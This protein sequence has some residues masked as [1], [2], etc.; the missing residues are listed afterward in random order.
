MRGG[1]GRGG[2]GMHYRGQQISAEQ[3]CT[4]EQHSTAGLLHHNATISH[5]LVHLARFIGKGVLL[6]P[7]GNLTPRCALRLPSLWGRPTSE[8]T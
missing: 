4:S 5:S 2:E 7:G 6:P 8:K 1:A 3:L